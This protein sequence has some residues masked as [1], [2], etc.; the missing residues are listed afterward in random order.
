[1]RIYTEVFPALKAHLGT[2]AAVRQAPQVAAY[3]P[4]RARPGCND[5]VV[6][7]EHC[8][9]CLRQGACHTALR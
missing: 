8:G 7:A 5:S 3:S 2:P 4:G 9:Y 1:M 6:T